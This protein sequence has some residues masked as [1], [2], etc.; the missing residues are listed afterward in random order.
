MSL[1]AVA[2]RWETP[3]PAGVTE[4][5]AIDVGQ[6][7]SLLVIL[8]DG[9]T[10]LVDA[11]GIPSFD[12]RLRSRMDIGEDV[13]SP[14]LWRRGLRRLDY[15]AVTHLHDDH[16][17]GMP[18]VIRN[19]RPREVWTGLAPESSSLLGRIREAARAAG[20]RLESL[21]KGDGRAGLRVLWPP[22]DA[23]AGAVAKNDDSLVLLIFN[24][25]HKFLL[26]GDAEQPVE[27]GMAV[28]EDIDV[29][30]AGHHG[31][32]TSTTPVLLD[33]A[34]PLFAAISSGEGNSYG[35]PHPLV[36]QRLNAA[37]TRVFRT[38]LSGA[39]QFQS[40][41]IRLKTRNSRE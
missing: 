38:D 6:G 15:V 22:R 35:H 31:S 23:H 7:D 19:F 9:K 16:A 34:R 12:P 29:L 37:G 40:D 24:G 39:I 20:S 8:P 5:S 25:R 14:Y 26:M 10:L 13:V 3:L 21:H 4:V 1:A 32:R 36:L 11:G 27:Y 18:A 41:G 30:K 28:P 2:L 33:R 17:G